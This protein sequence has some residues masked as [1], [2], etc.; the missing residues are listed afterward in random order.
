MYGIIISA[1]GICHHH[2]RR[3][4]EICQHHG[5]RDKGLALYIE[6]FLLHTRALIF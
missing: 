3:H 1:V 2:Y 6:V 4:E 5:L